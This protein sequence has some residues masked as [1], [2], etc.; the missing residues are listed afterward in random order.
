MLLPAAERAVT[1]LRKVQDGFY[2][3]RQ[4][5]RDE[6]DVVN[7][8]AATGKLNL[9][10]APSEYLEMLRNATHGFGSNNSRRVGLTNTLLAHHDGDVPHDIGF[11]GYLY[12]LDLMSQPEVLRGAL[13]RGG[14]L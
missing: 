4:F 7:S 11:L 3:A 5:G 6:I 13:Y 14:R 10:D 1:A 2:L 8:G 12:L 9:E